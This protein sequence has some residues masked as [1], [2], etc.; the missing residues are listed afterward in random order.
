VSQKKESQPPSTAKGK[1]FSKPFGIEILF[2]PL[3][4]VCETGRFW[5]G[6]EWPGSVPKNVPEGDAVNS[7]LV[8]HLMG[9]GAIACVFE[10]YP[11]V[12]LMIGITL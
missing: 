2:Y 1:R 9:A 12:D 6:F 7:G 10:V 3:P 11:D 5:D 4:F 8:N